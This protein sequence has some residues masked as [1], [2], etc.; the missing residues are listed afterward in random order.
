VLSAAIHL[1][2]QYFNHV[3]TENSIHHESS[4][5]HVLLVELEAASVPDATDMADVHSVTYVY[6]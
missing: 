5:G 1:Q 6:A 2:Y 3:S 4:P